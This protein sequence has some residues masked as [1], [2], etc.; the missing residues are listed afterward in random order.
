MTSCLGVIAA[1]LGFTSIGSTVVDQ[2]QADEGNPIIAVEPPAQEPQ[3]QQAN[4][5]DGV[6]HRMFVNYGQYIPQDI[7]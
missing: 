4:A 3:A 6:F 5:A 1:I 7:L 2:T